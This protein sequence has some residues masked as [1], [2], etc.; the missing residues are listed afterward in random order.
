MNQ[1]L[2]LSDFQT[3]TLELPETFDLF[4]GGGRGGAKSHTMAFLAL[5]HCEQ[6]KEKARILYIRQTYRGL[7]DFEQI[8]LDL[9][10][11]LYGKSARYNA[12]ENIWRMPGGGY[13]ELGQLQSVKD[14]QKYQGRSFTLLLVDEAGQ[15]G[16]PTMLDKLRSNLRGPKSM[17]IRMVVAANPGGPGHHWI[18]QRYVFKSAKP[19]TP[20]HEER[21]G[22]KWVYAPS[23]YKDNPFIDQAEYRKQLEA[24][25][26]TD[27][28][29]LRAWLEG[30]WSVARGAF[31]ASVI[32]E[33]RNAIDPVKKIPYGWR[34]FLAHDY[35]SSAPSVTYVI[36]ES[37]GQAIGDTFYPRGSYL[38]LDELA[39][40]VP[41][42]INEGMGYT[43][44]V[45]AERIKEMCRK[46]GIRPDG[47]ADDAC[48]S[49]HGHSAGSIANEFQKE[50]VYF[51]RAKKG[52][53][54][55][56][57]ETMRRLLQDAGKPDKP[58]LYVSRGCEYFWSTV[59]FIGRDPN[60]VEDLDTRAADHAADAIRYG[61]NHGPSKTE[62]IRLGVI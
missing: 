13:L 61:V 11:Q 43:V 49:K 14:Y 45:L 60:N 51:R 34:T 41:D 19:F 5:R 17:P 7:A 44:P 52:D 36:T 22:R 35:G 46:W 48:F 50:G 58:G 39:T 21:S 33:S 18:A 59:P 15:Y 55:S 32:E 62:S 42:D 25:S 1:T 26:P 3:Q 8:C 2:E 53:R 38:V 30:D 4:L 16:V 6:Y 56:G 20:F 29:L 47:V 40:N 57:W 54:K 9:F 24:S 12:S 23:T 37:P 27:Q 28:E 10:G 31:F